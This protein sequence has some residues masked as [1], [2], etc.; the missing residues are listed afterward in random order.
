MVARL[1]IARLMSGPVPS[2]ERLAALRLSLIAC[3]PGASEGSSP[4]CE[5]KTASVSSP[6]AEKVSLMLTGVLVEFSL[7]HP[8]PVNFG[9]PV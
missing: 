4:G 6:I 8:G 7:I 9:P 1:R 3:T 2:S 5:P